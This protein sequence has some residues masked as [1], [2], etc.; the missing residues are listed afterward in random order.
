MISL[1]CEIHTEDVYKFSLL[2]PVS[3]LLHTYPK[4]HPNYRVKNMRLPGMFMDD[5]AFVPIVSFVKLHSKIT[6]HFE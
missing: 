1:V 2:M 3:F 4:D 6:L 5:N